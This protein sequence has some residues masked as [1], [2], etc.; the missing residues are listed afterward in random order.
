MSCG[1]GRQRR[2]VDCIRNDGKIVHPFHCRVEGRRI[3]A[4][5]RMCTVP[6]PRNCGISEWGTWSNCQNKCGAES[7]QRRSRFILA[8]AENGGQS[9]LESEPLN[10]KKCFSNIIKFIYNIRLLCLIYPLYIHYSNNNSKN[11]I[12]V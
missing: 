12:L 3:P 7:I 1:I 5:L 10:G 11:I 2:L 8:R 4:L 9:C 6:C